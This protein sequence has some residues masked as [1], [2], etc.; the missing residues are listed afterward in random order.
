M[1]DS[2]GRTPRTD[3]PDD[4]GEPRSPE[5]IEADLERT[6]A[7]LGQTVDALS[8]KLDVKSRARAQLRSVTTCLQDQVSATRSR[9]GTLTAKGKDAV[10]DEGGNLNPTV[11]AAAVATIILGA[12]VVVF[13][14]RRRSGR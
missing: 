2:D 10:T 6:R 5:E 13:V 4:A 12:G 7:E 1:S 8:A 14:L 9:A 3:L 11:P